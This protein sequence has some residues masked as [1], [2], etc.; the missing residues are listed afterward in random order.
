MPRPILPALAPAL[1]FALGLAALPAVPAAAQSQRVLTIFGQDKCP[2]DTICVRAPERERYR[3]PKELRQST[4]SPD[5]QSWAARAQSVEYVGRSGTNSCS[6]SG[7]GGW[8]G[9]YSKILEQA[10]AERRAAAKG[11]LPES[12]R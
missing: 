10:R 11:E 4:P 1:A 3:I 12:P 6:T 2:E 9:C 8:T 5:D 7:S